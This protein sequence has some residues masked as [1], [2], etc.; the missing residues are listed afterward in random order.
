MELGIN[1]VPARLDTYQPHT[2]VLDEVI[3]CSNGIT[4]TTDTCDDGIGQLA[5]L[6]RE[7]R[8]DFAPDD[9]LEIT[10][11]GREG[12][13]ANSGSNEVVRVIESRHPLAHRLVD[14][15]LERLR[16][17]RHGNDL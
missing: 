13:R 3:E 15:V 2:L 6:F 5:L 4:A 10:D 16:A 9:A 1:T 7:L 12:V 14:G 8:L 17:R 11:N